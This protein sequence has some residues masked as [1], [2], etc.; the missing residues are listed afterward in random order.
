M[1]TWTREGIAELKEDDLSRDV[2]VP[3]FEG[4]GYRDV[5]FH[6]GGVLEQ[7]KDIVMFREEPVRGRVNIAVVV[8]SR[9][10]NGKMATGDVVNQL[11]EAFGKKYLD[12]ATARELSIHE[13]FVVT[14]GAISKQGTFALEGL[15]ANEPFHDRV[16]Y[17]DGP[18]LWQYIETYLGARVLL[19]KLTDMYRRLQDVAPNVGLELNGDTLTLKPKGYA[20]TESVIVTPKFTDTPEGK[21]NREAFDR[22]LK[23]GEPTVLPATTFE[24]LPVPEFMHTLGIEIEKGLIKVGGSGRPLSGSLILRAANGES[25]NFEH[26]EFNVRGGTEQISLTNEA[27]NIPFVFKM[28]VV[29]SPDG[30]PAGSVNYS[31]DVEGWSAHWL[32]KQQKAV[33]LMARGCAFAFKDER[34]GIEHSFGV[35][36]P[37]LIQTSNEAFQELVRQLAWVEARVKEPILVPSRPF[38]TAEDRNNLDFVRN[39]IKGGQVP[40][41]SAKFT[42]VPVSERRGLLIDALKAQ[43]AQGLLSSESSSWPVLETRVPLGP[44]ELG[45]ASARLLPTLPLDEA[46]AAIERGEA[47]EVRVEPKKGSRLNIRHLWWYKRKSR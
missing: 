10:I 28:T 26:I 6:G 36:Q 9:T 3:L 11:R 35:A 33:R 12:T 15:V 30:Q 13:C 45:G 5:R 21:S 44:V 42:L 27:Q 20:E 22:F 16:E 32:D 41:N 29:F 23:T 34:T 24:G 2:L 46:I 39:V 47:I 31:S 4:M 37:G 8:K 14:P 43:S 17:I 18:R 38:F 1:T 19:P 7:G 25:V 40:L